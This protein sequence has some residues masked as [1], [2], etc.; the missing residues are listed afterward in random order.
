M[1]GTNISRANGSG[2][3]TN[4]FT[5]S[6]WAKR[7]ITDAGR[8]FS[9]TGGSGDV[10]F[11][12]NSGGFIEW[13]GH[14]SNAS[15]AGYFITNRKFR[16]YNGWYHF[17]IRFDST[18]S[19]ATD[20]LRFYVNGTQQESFSSYT[21]VNQNAT[22]N[23]SLS[24]NTHYWGGAASSQYFDGS[25]S[26]IHYTV[27]YDYGPDSFGE[28]D[29]T[30]GEW[31]IKEDPSGITY[32][33]AGYFILKDGAVLTDSSPNSNNFAVANG[34]LTKTEDCPS[35]IFSTLN[36]LY[37]QTSGQGVSLA[38]G[39]TR[40]SYSPDSSRSAFGSI[41]VGTG[42]YYF[43][44]KLN[45]V[46]TIPVIGVVDLAWG[47]LNGASGYGYHDN[48]LNFGYNSSGE[49]T[50]GGTNTAFGSTFT[51]GDVIGVAIDK[52]NNKLYFA[53]NGTWQASGDP[54]SGSTGTGSAYNLASDTLYTSACRIRNGGDW[55]FNFGNG[56]FGTTAISSEG[57]NASGVGKFEYDVPAG[58]TALATKGLNE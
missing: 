21:N 36:P 55:S 11:R 3:A 5:L 34:T 44:A 40:C 50:S 56:F 10:Y 39:N 17:V 1:A 4:K 28:T 46:G 26:H 51:A 38:N 8:M 13:S 48:A 41:A 57:T 6:F 15:S 45:T 58:Y 37:N 29:S 19:T 18:Q 24:S 12:F 42:K 32:G 2:S 52:T 9:A 23:I 31:K 16:D 30:T 14:G 7:G 35:N 49:K 54:T 43:E 25:M 20:R 53:K 47:D 27:G 33:S 22:D